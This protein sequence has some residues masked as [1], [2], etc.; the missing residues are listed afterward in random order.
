M[1]TSASYH[2]GSY[3]REHDG[4]PRLFRCR[5]APP[6]NSSTLGPG[7]MCTRLREVTIWVLGGPARRFPRIVGL[8]VHSSGSG[9]R[10]CNGN[11]EFSCY[12]SCKKQQKQQEGPRATVCE[13]TVRQC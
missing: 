7:L 5:R 3:R 4:L 10:I 8:G 2:F 6:P 1:L 12:F 9:L 11:C 13:G